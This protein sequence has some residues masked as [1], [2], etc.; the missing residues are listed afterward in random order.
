M[1]T[2]MIV[3]GSEEKYKGHFY[4]GPL[5]CG[6]HAV[7]IGADA[8]AVSNDVDGKH[9]CEFDVSMLPTG[10]WEIYKNS[11]KF[12]IFVFLMNV[13]L[14]IEVLKTFFCNR[15]ELNSYKHC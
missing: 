3:S 8:F 14:I 10:I 15:Y 5:A 2:G 12:H 9:F 6:N 7:L 11:G 1:N 4:R 13:H